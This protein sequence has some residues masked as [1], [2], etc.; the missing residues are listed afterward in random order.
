MD[1]IHINNWQDLQHFGI[2]ALTGEA[3][4][5]STRILCDVNAEGCA[6]LLDYFGLPPQ[7]IVSRPWN[8]RVKDEPA[9]GSFML[10]RH[11]LRQLAEFALLRMEAKAI[12]YR[13][14]DATVGL[15]TDEL[16][17]N[18]EKLMQ[19]MPSSTKQ[20]GIRRNYQLPKAVGSRN[21]H[22]F[23]NRVV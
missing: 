1:S 20:W 9:I 11:S 8:A 19:E 21:V 16:L 10:H 14:E 23:T 2:N 12:V 17:A 4:A 7:G 3:C 15:F 6:L 5:Y 22:M 18:Y 13:G